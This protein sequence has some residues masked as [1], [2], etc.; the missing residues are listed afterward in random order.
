MKNDDNKQPFMYL[1]ELLSAKLNPSP[2]P[3][4]FSDLIGFS[5]ISKPTS[6]LPSS[7]PDF[8]SRI[9]ETSPE[10]NTSLAS[11]FAP[12]I[13]KGVDLARS[14]FAPL[15]ESL[16]PP[17]SPV[18][19]GRPTP[20][21]FARPL[22]RIEPP[23]RG[24]GMSQS[25]ALMQEMG[26]RKVTLN[27]GRV[28]PTIDDLAI[29]EARKVRAAFL[30]SDLHGY[31]KIVA[32]TPTR[33]SVLLMQ[34]FVEFLVRITTHYGGS[35]VDCAGDRIL[36]VFSRP[37]TDRSPDPVREAITAALWA[38][39]VL[40]KVIAPEFKKIGLPGDVSAAM[41]IDYGPVAATCVGIRNNKRFIFSGDAA[42][43]AAKLQD[44]GHGGEI[45]ISSSAYHFKP[46]F[47]DGVS[48]RPSFM[49]DRV[50]LSQIFVDGVTEPPKI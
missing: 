1:S 5:N 34:A 8:L 42:N 46:S 47:L 24:V 28:L 48:W 22:G 12:P 23:I 16:P 27:G 17:P 26:Q 29:L 31:T 33:Q 14:I 6:N 15:P 38:Q 50:H 9:S 13:V 18:T 44:M 37:E 32:S 19:I 36:S 4:P 21:P 45:V 30:Y 40:Q 2:S 39:T 49:G 11:L 41:G 20:P 43:N 35:V 7:L 3:V 10:T 25:R